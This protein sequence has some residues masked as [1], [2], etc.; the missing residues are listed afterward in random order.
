[1]EQQIKC[2]IV[3]ATIIKNIA[4][5]TLFIVVFKPTLQAQETEKFSFLSKMYF[6]FEFGTMIKTTSNLSSIKFA[7]TGIEYR[8]KNDKGIFIRFDYVN[9]SGKFDIQ[10]NNATNVQKGELI[11]EDYTLG[12]G[13]RVGSKKIKYIILIKGGLCNYSYPSINGIQPNYEVKTTYS[14]TSVFK[15]LIGVEYYIYKN[16]AFVLCTDYTLLTTKTLFW[17]NQFNGIGVSVGLTTTL[18]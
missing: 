1:M 2:I 7:N 17:G 9:R 6:P 3:K 14:N 4:L 8:L 15:S 18:F 12:I 5:I 10:N 16:A 13:S 11:F